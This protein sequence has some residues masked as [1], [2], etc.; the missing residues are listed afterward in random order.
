MHVSPSPKGEQCLTIH[1]LLMTRGCAGA[2]D[3]AAVVDVTGLNDERA[4]SQIERQ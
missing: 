3:N 4:V 2:C 1:G